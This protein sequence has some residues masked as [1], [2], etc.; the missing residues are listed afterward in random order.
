[1]PLQLECTGPRNRYIRCKRGLNARW[2][3]RLIHFGT[4]IPADCCRMLDMCTNKS[5]K[6]LY[7]WPVWWFVE[8]KCHVPCRKYHRLR[9][10]ASPVLT[11]THHS[12][13]SLKLSDFFSGSRLEVRPPQPILTQ[14]G[15][16]DVD[17]RK[18]VPFAVKIATFHTPWSPG[19]LKGQNFANL[20]T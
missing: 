3:R 17:S 7:L 12:Y 4:A 11:A 18:D 1:M 15:S 8:P 6:D 16:I 14:N 9:G 2:G 13:G 5:R 19:P 20:W 10:S